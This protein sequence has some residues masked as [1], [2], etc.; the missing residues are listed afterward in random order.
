[1]NN[2][3]EKSEKGFNNYFIYGLLIAL[4]AIEYIPNFRSIE[5]IGPQYLYLSVLNLICIFYI[6]VNRS[7]INPQYLPTLK[8]TKHII[9]YAIFVLLSAI[10][11]FGANNFS[12][13][14]VNFSH[15]FIILI[16][17]LNLSILLFNKKEILPNLVFFV[18]I[19]LFVITFTEV[20]HMFKNFNKISLFQI[21]SSFK[22]NS[23]N[24]N[25]FA[26]SANIK[27]PFLAFAILYF[28]NWKKYFA[29]T[30][31]FFAS[32]VVFL[33][34]ARAAYL[35]LFLIIVA[36]LIIYNFKYSDS[37]KEKIY[38]SLFVVI[39]IVLSFLL[40]NLIFNTKK[41]EGR[42]ESVV[43][44]VTQLAD[45]KVQDQS[46]N[47]RKYYWKNSL[48]VIK[49]NPLFGVG[50]G[51]W[52]I[53][54]LPY[55]KLEADNLLISEHSHNDFLE[56]MAETGIL[57]GLVYLLLFIL[58][59]SIN[60][61]TILKSDD[62]TKKTIAL[63]S[64]LMLLG[65]LADCMFNF[66]LHRTAIQMWFTIIMVFTLVNNHENVTNSQKSISTLPFILATLLSFG[67][68]F[69]SHSA[70]E[71]YRLENDITA[72]IQGG[73]DYLTSQDIKN[74]LPFC[75]NVFT[76]SEPFTE[77]LGIYLVK[78]KK[79]AEA[80]KYLN[81]ANTINPHNGRVEWY[82][83][84]IANE[85]NKKD[86]AYI[87]AKQA[88]K[89]RPR[90]Y[91][92]YLSVLFMANEFKDTTE[93][94]RVHKIYDGYVKKPKNWIDTS[95]ALHLSNFNKK[96][97]LNFINEGVKL[98]PQD[99][100]LLERRKVFEYELGAL[101]PNAKFKTSNT[102]PVTPTEKYIDFLQRA[103]N[104]G[105]EGRFDKSLECY[106]QV[107][108]IDPKNITVIQNIGICYFK[109]NKFQQAINELEKTLGAPNLNDGK[110]EYILGI[111]YLNIKNSVKAC[112]YIDIAT[113]KNFP[114]AAALKKQ[115]CK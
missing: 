74:R 112:K 106:E 49:A 69:I 111:S 19:S 113:T 20:Y 43:G 88:F 100:A 87:Y 23:G 22:G 12:L 57:N 35:G 31:L 72:D 96:N 2:I 37:K 94:L 17:A 84:R 103:I 13:W 9:V 62:R 60:I 67:C 61:K 80:L 66:P 65:Y 4:L 29:I 21:L 56:V 36:F 6:F 46:I 52:R 10:S 98:Y 26:V 70:F 8:K 28:D 48:L 64:I 110:T 38:N 76:N 3:T 11:G 16:L 89:I 77:Q 95:N 45:S 114:G 15:V 55:E 90:N 14:I 58:L 40:T 7:K 104:F 92:Y 24:I 109:L 54:S 41:G 47:L 32:L 34:S 78:E 59:V 71:A 42:F 93:M 81:I 75:P 53:E 107:H 83:H 33:I 99:S 85:N 44:R 51:N 18:T 108:K 97:I 86:S 105:N 50:M 79:Y 102:K 68:V 39:P 25:I 101:N 91:D 1:M 73:K 30:T 82:K 115:Y 5:I 63:I 27:I